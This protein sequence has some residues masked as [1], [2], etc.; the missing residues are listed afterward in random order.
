[1][2][3]PCALFWHLGWGDQIQAIKS[4]IMEIGDIF[5]VNKK[6]REGSY[7]AIKDIEDA[8]AMTPRSGW[9]PPVVATEALSGDGIDE[10]LERIEEHRKY[11]SSSSDEK[12]RKFR[13]QVRVAM[14]DE[15]RAIVGGIL[16]SKEEY[17]ERMY[18]QSDPPYS[19]ARE[20]IEDALKNS[21]KELQR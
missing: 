18:G 13:N 17:I 16:S 6:D 20:L 9:N 2:P 11:F 1:M 4:G 7:M 15:L 3:I 8:L 19:V 12:A 5:V 10:L 21:V 14:E